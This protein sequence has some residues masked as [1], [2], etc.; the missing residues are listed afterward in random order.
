MDDPHSEFALSDYLAVL[1][2]RKYWFAGVALTVFGLVALFTL[3]QDPVYVAR[4]DVLVRTNDTERLFTVPHSLMEHR[5]AQS[6]S[7]EIAYVQGEQFRRAAITN[8]GFVTVVLPEERTVSAG[9]RGSTGIIGFTARESS[10]QRAADAA[11][12]YADTYITLRHEL[13]ASSVLPEYEA[14]VARREAELDAAT[15][16]LEQLLDPV[17]RIEE[18]IAVTDDPFVVGALIEQQADLRADAELLRPAA[19][20]Q[21]EELETELTRLRSTIELVTGSKAIAR[22]LN[23]AGAPL[24]P[25]SPKVERNLALGA[26][27]ALVLGFAA[28]MARDLIDP[29]VGEKSQDTRFEGIPLLATIP[30]LPS[31]RR[32]PG[33]VA[34]FVDLPVDH[35]DA[36]RSLRNSLML[37]STTSDVE[38][39]AFTSGRPNVGKTQTVAN[40]A[41]ALA[42]N[43]R[44]V[45][46]VDADLRAG[47]LA[48]RL[49]IEPADGISE[50]L[51]GG[52]PLRDLVAETEID[53][54][55]VLSRGM[56]QPGTLDAL[57]PERMH[58]LIEALRKP[59]RHCPHRLPTCARRP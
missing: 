23:T 5:F 24:S 32:A 43:R 31:R 53:R 30:T 41:Q 54:L 38:V 26:I 40:V 55:T 20:S 37:L 27:A 7:A 49:G 13:F 42:Q 51:S 33:R 16:R 2:R 48:D 1:R 15:T 45:L 50:Y 18:L 56:C 39:V 17:D 44:R 46:V 29:R 10:A 28:A 52:V 34:P 8:A 19:R 58:E 12:A 11:N 47:D 6:M 22:V 36:Y 14:A 59:F 4:A 35:V 25:V 9:A 57:T 3:S 21:V